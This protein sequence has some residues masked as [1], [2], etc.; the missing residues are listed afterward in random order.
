MQAIRKGLDAGVPALEPTVLPE[1]AVPIEEPKAES[2]T[3][4]PAQAKQAP[5]PWILHPVIDSLFCCGGI[6]W[7]LLFAVLAGFHAGLDCGP[8]GVTLLLLNGLGQVF[9]ADAH[10]PATLWRVYLSPRTRQSV[11]AFVTICGITTLALGAF[12]LYNASFT[13]GLVVVTLA[14]SIQHLLAQ[15]YGVSLIY[16]Y[17]RGYM[18]SNNERQIFYYLFQT[19]LAFCVI[20]MFTYSSFLSKDLYGLKI[21]FWGPL[22]E[23]ICYLSLAAF[24]INVLLFVGMVARKWMREKRHFPLPAL[25]A[26]LTALMLPLLNHWEPIAFVIFVQTFYHASQ[27]IVVTTA[28]YLKEQG[29]PEGVPLSR[30]SSLLLKPVT[31][32]YIGVITILGLLMF[33]ALPLS[34]AAVGFDRSVAYCVVYCIFNIHHYITDSAIWRMKDPE[35]RKLLVS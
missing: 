16:C 7:L 2:T 3:A 28:Y 26:T 29:M 11:G 14:W 33:V 22:P 5:Y 23:W 24:Q 12:G 17:K 10:Q 15:A 6:L 35:V 19:G 20:R 30:I 32:K 1:M 13:A 34:L 27:Y 9:F 4:S 21:P 8:A 25:A 18:M 31:L